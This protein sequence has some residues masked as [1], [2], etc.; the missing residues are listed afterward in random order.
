MAS[1]MTI[2]PLVPSDHSHPS[3]SNLPYLYHKLLL[4]SPSHLYA[5]DPQNQI[6]RSVLMGYLSR[7]LDLPVFHQFPVRITR[8]HHQNPR[9]YQN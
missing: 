2:F 7:Y 4:R 9:C 1:N 6:C 5:S 3:I 8:H